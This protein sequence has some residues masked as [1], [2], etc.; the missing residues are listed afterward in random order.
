MSESTSTA[1]PPALPLTFGIELEHILAF[2]SS[3]LLPILPP[4]T[5]II[6]DIPSD[7]RWELRQT[8]PLYHLTRPLYQGWGV[9]APSNYPTTSGAD[10]RNECIRRH[11]CRGYADEVLWI[12]RNI[13][14]ARGKEVV[15]HDGHGKMQEFGKWYLTTD[16]SLV[17]A[18]PQE[19]AIV[20]GSD[21]VQNRQW[22]SGPAEL[23]SRVLN[24]DDKS[25]FQE[26]G[27]MLEIL[28]AGNDG[29]ETG[30]K[31]FA[32]QWC[33]LHVHIGLPPLS[34]IPSSLPNNHG[35]IEQSN[36]FPLLILQHLAYIT[37]IYEPIL[38]LL[39]PPNRRPE[40]PNAATDLL[41]NRE[42]IYEDPDFSTI[43]WD[44]V[45]DSGYA[46]DSSVE[47]TGE[48]RIKFPTDP[49][50][51]KDKGKKSTVDNNRSGDITANAQNTDSI[52]T[53][54]ANTNAQ[55]DNNNNNNN[56]D[57]NELNS[58]PRL[59]ARAHTLI[60][61]G[62]PCPKMSLQTLISLMSSGRDR[63]RLINWTY[64]SRSVT[65]EHISQ[66]GPGTLEFRQHEACFDAREIWLWVRFCAGLVR[67][68]ERG[69]RGWG[70]RGARGWG[71]GE[72]RRREEEEEVLG[73]VYGRGVLGVRGLVEGMGLRGEERE[74]VG[75]R[76]GMWRGGEV[77]KG[78]GG[79]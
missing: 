70:E 13:F 2:H 23:V 43:D 28:N 3:H 5:K 31:A 21:K 60:F 1:M 29:G 63:R 69:A 34:P 9:T 50:Y 71:E 6:K 56:E 62:P 38:S 52:I 33:G 8:T 18:T 46:S 58:E 14:K 17:G 15:L 42:G 19:L 10:W 32:D 20:I 7:K 37:I 11:G 12:E 66:R 74:W 26:I 36:T 45:S 57:E 59:R 30:Y 76:V 24:V 72:G 61:P 27:D 48:R 22:D 55:Q 78:E 75:R 54:D 53:G 67:W 40:H 68:A 77:E 65:A 73:E 25:S 64:L 41:G 49:K 79:R 39:H 44:A 51:R 16:T 35:T 47:S 4:K